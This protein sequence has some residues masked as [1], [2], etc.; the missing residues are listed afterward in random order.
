MYN[1]LLNKRLVELINETLSAAKSKSALE[2][3]NMIV[4]GLIKD[5]E[6]K[7]KEVK[8]YE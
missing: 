2:P 6:H 5:L 7:L 3:E 4:K 8:S 1:E